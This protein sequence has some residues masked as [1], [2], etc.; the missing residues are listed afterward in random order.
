MGLK[1]SRSTGTARFVDKRAGRLRRDAPPA[2]VVS[3]GG[4]GLKLL[5]AHR[6]PSRAQVHPLIVGQQR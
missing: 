1:A 2:D 5:R 3:P 6:I 4:D